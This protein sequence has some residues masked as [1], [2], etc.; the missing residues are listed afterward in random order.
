M[1]AAKTTG[2]SLS[3]VATRIRTVGQHPC[4]PLIVSQDVAY[5]NDNWSAYKAEAGGKLCCVWVRET[6]GYSLQWWLTRH[7]AVQRLGEAVRRIADH[8]VAVWVMNHISS[9]SY[10][11]VMVVLRTEQRANHGLPV[12]RP[13]ALRALRRA[14]LYKSIDKVRACDSCKK[15]KA[16][17][18]LL[19]QT[20]LDLG[21]TIPGSTKFGE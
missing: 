3:E 2:L 1:V 11:K 4:A 6:S 14:G 20:I 12:M 17:I 16:R 5:L 18:K 7:E 19:E 10:P 15:L 13:V 8:G 9:D 21:G